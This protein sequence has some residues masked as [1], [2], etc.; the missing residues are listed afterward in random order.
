MFKLM[1]EMQENFCQ[2]MARENIPVGVAAFRAGYGASKHKTYDGYHNGVGK[3]LMTDPK[4]I[5]RINSIKEE[6]SH[7]ESDFSGNIVK[8]LKNIVDFDYGKYFDSTNITMS[9]GRTVTDYYLNTDLQKWKTEDR[10]LI[11][12]GYDSQGR[13][14]FIDKQWAID[15][16]LR[17]YGLDGKNAMDVEDMDTLYANAGIDNDDFT[18][19][20]DGNY[21]EELERELSSNDG[22]SDNEDVS[23]SDGVSEEAYS[24]DYIIEEDEVDYEEDSDFFLGGDE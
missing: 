1:N 3:R 23:S 12:N 14:K 24:D 10:K 4:V 17:I 6:M 8:I 15:K 20:D 13:P 16:L 21:E 9:N 19:E 5:E 22:V 11:I 18:D 2:I 7:E